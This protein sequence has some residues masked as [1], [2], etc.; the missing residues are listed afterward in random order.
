M[1]YNHNKLS[2]QLLNNKKVGLLGGSF[3]PAHAGHLAMSK[4]ALHK[5]ELD[6]I[7]WL[8]VP[9][10]PLK[11][12]YKMTLEERASYA[13]KVADHERIIISTLEQEI[14]SKNTYDTLIYLRKAFPDTEFTW[15]MGADCLAQFHEW[16]EFDQFANLVNIAIFNRKGCENYNYTTSTIGGRMLHKESLK[17]NGFRVLF[18]DNELVD[19]SSTEIR[20]GI[21]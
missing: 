15:L 21:K 4:Y 6:Y 16:E 10:N 7:I 13:A 3:N 18:C 8:V 1:N 20:A 11:P 17:N 19:I 2:L 5:L 14:E 9:Q 12:P